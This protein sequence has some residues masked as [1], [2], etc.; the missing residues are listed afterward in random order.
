MLGMTQGW[1][2]TRR[3]NSPSG[4]GYAEGYRDG[5]EESLI[6]MLATQVEVLVEVDGERRPLRFIPVE[7]VETMLASRNNR[8]EMH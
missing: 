8:A 1:S 6:E 5:Y 3:G 4:E 2:G 7:L